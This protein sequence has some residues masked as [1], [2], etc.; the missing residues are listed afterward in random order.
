MHPMKLALA[1][2]LL[3][4][5]AVSVQAATEYQCGSEAGYQ[6]IETH[7]GASSVV[8]LHNSNNDA[9][10]TLTATNM[11]GELIPLGRSYDNKDWEVVA[12][13]FVEKGLEFSCS[14]NKCTV[15]LSIVVGDA[16]NHQDF[17]LTSFASY[18]DSATEQQTIIARFLEQAT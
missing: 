16:Q 4:V 5:A 1:C 8:I 13:P 3:N 18:L 14:S 6:I 17:R 11:N 9:L 10:C 12:G 2:L 7:D 15:D